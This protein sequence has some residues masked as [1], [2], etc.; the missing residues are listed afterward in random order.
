MSIQ[1]IQLTRERMHFFSENYIT[2]VR[3]NIIRYKS[4]E[5]QLLQA[6]VFVVLSNGTAHQSA[7]APRAETFF[8]N[9]YLMIDTSGLINFVTHIGPAYKL[10]EKKNARSAISFKERSK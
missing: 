6:A 7:T 8:P 5:I 2:T 1:K 4:G 3:A 9:S 10:L